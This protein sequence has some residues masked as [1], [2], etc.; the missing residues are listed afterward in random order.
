MKTTHSSPASPPGTPESRFRREQRY[1]LSA[2]GKLAEQAYRARI[3]ESRVSIGG[4]RLAFES[5][6]SAWATK[7]AIEPDDGFYLGELRAKSMTL[8]ELGENL[9]ICS[10]TRE[11]VR[12]SVTRMLDR[13]LLELSSRP[14]RA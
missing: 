14:L 3:R 9:A 5:A 6:R 12:D 2:D 13:G 8:R 10:Q 7:Y 11:N 4:G 1:Q